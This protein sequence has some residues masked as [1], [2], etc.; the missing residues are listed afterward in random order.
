MGRWPLAKA[1]IAR[2]MAGRVAPMQKVAGSKARNGTRKQI[3]QRQRSGESRPVQR[4]II[5]FAKGM[6]ARESAPQTAIDPSMAAYQWAGRLLR[7]MGLSSSQAP[8]DNPPKKAVITA[9]T[10]PSSWP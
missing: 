1:A 8:R 6:A 5:R 3:V 10:L 2:S 7:E 9:R 4:K